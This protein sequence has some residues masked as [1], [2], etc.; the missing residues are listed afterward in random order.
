MAAS[1]ARCSK[2]GLTIGRRHS[3]FSAA[4]TDD[5]QRHRVT[6]QHGSC[7]RADQTEAFVL[8]AVDSLRSLVAVAAIPDGE[9]STIADN[10]S[11]HFKLSSKSGRI[12]SHATVLE[13]AEE[14]GVVLPFGCRSGVCGQCKTKLTAGRVKMYAEDALLESEIFLKK[15]ESRF[16]NLG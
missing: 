14:M 9:L 3:S 10:A 1:V 11:I 5:D 6:C 4:A 2:R 13:A 16:E 7:A 8:P 15:E 12:R